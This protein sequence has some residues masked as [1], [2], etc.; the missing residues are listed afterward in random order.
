MMSPQAILSTTK[1][2]FAMEGMYASKTDEKNIIDVLTGSRSLEDVINE[3][4]EKY[5]AAGK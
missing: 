3:L 5:T 1:G 4:K 2:S